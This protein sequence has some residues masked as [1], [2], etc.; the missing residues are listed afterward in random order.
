MDPDVASQ[1]SDHDK[2]FIRRYKLLRDANQK[3]KYTAEEELNYRL[4][5]KNVRDYI[6]EIHEINKK[7]SNDLKKYR[8]I[9]AILDE[10]DSN[11]VRLDDPNT[12]PNYISEL[13]PENQ[14]KITEFGN[15]VK[16]F[17]D[18]YRMTNDLLKMV[19]MTQSI[20]HG[21]GKS[22]RKRRKT[23]KRRSKRN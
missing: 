15:S 7:I 20:R 13:S 22:K 18:T 19:N 16:Q 10:T 21:T 11:I 1:P 5:E 2:Y 3:A 9:V 17:N 12:Y 8:N 23:S 6:K 4:D 14:V